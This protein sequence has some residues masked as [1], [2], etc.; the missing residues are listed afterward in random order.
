MSKIT[1]EGDLEN[2]SKQSKS[3]PEENILEKVTTFAGQETSSVVIS[4]TDTLMSLKNVHTSYHSF[5]LQHLMTP[6]ISQYTLIDEERRM[7][8]IR[9]YFVLPCSQD[10][11]S[12]DINVKYVYEDHPSQHPNCFYIYYDGP[13]PASHPNNYNIFVAE[14]LFFQKK[15]RKNG[16]YFELIDTDPRTSRG[17]VTTVAQA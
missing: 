8:E 7:Y 17:T 3:E 13:Q 12:K 2:K 9:V 4:K 1:N 5:E 6:L 14:V 15:G 16:I 10:I 11:S